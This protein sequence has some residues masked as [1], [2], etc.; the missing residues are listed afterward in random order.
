[1]AMTPWSWTSSNG[2]A[3]AAETIRAYMALTGKMNTTNFSYKVWN[4]LI[5]KINA[6]NSALGRSWKTEYETYQKTR[7]TGTYDTLTAEKFN[8]ARYNTNYP[9][10]RWAYDTEFEGFTGRTDMKGVSLY[11]ETAADTVFG[12][13]ILELVKSLNIVIG[14]INGTQDSV[15]MS[16]N[17]PVILQPETELVRASSV[18]F[19]PLRQRMRLRVR[20]T[21][22]SDNLPTLTLHYH[23]PTALYRAF[24]EL[25]SIASQLEGQIRQSVNIRGNL[26]RS[27]ILALSQRISAGETATANL[28]S[29]PV[30]SF[31]GSGR[32]ELDIR[33]RAHSFPG[34]FLITENDIRSS[35]SGKGTALKTTSIGW[36]HVRII[37]EPDS[38][39]VQEIRRVLESSVKGTIAPIARFD[40]LQS[41][42][43]M[44][45]ESAGMI[46]GNANM[47][48]PQTFPLS[49][50]HDVSSVWH[51]A[52][53]HLVEFMEGLSADIRLSPLSTRAVLEKEH[54]STMLEAVLASALI[55][56]ADP[57]VMITGAMERHTEILL[58][59][60]ALLS[61]GY[62]SAL[63]WDIPIVLEHTADAHVP[64]SSRL[65]WREKIKLAMAGKA[66]VPASASAEVISQS[67]LKVSGTVTRNSGTVRFSA[68][69]RN[70]HNIIGDISKGRSAGIAAEEI[71]A[72][73][74]T[75]ASLDKYGLTAVSAEIS[76]SHI[77]AAELADTSDIS[78]H[79]AELEMSLTESSDLGYVMY[80]DM[81]AANAAV[82]VLSADIETKGAGWE[83]P[84][85]VGTDA[86]IFQVWLTEQC[87][88]HLCLDPHEAVHHLHISSGSSAGLDFVIRVGMEKEVDIHAA[89]MA[90][91]NIVRRSD[92]ESPVKTET[93]LYVPQALYARPAGQYKMEVL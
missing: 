15:D 52:E 26:G 67:R 19:D 16:E 85:I 10:W 21:L 56:S 64:H 54:I 27:Q 11:G 90:D 1:M 43:L 3:T 40:R 47:S 35:I 51:S 22:T 33:S 70:G 63:G 86:A 6:V 53:V 8:S 78:A 4:D 82:L 62:S 50:H 68:H 73:P 87:R 55:I 31:T 83:Y 12:A 60:P 66:N 48:L 72:E 88:N 80:A 17:V 5:S 13:Y 42:P 7:A 41:A 9:S 93:D 77:L 75:M 65:Q 20:P 44:F 61:G 30:G 76:F 74:N 46:I 81:N 58:E 92:W 34:S 36:H 23:I 28:R 2:T 71:L 25:E 49:I 57:E 89:I 32:Q 59:I 69:G 24:L 39:L 91:V 37:V 18:P 14:I 38:T 45:S 84:V 29:L 79:N